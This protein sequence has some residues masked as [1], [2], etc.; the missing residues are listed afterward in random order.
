MR[1]GR[2]LAISLALNAA[3]FAAILLLLR[4]PNDLARRTVGNA[5][6][7]ESSAVPEHRTNFYW[8]SLESADYRTYIANLRAISCP[9]ET[10]QDIIIADVNKLFAARQKELAAAFSQAYWQPR[11][12]VAV[13]TRLEGEN[14]LREL[15]QEKHHLIRELLG[16]ELSNTSRSPDIVSFDFIAPE[17]RNRAKMLH[18]KFNALEQAVFAEA[19]DEAMPIDAEKLRALRRERHAELATALSGRELEQYELRYHPAADALRR[20]LVGFSVSESEFHALFHL[21]KEHEDQF[22]FLDRADAAVQQAERV[23]LDAIEQQAKAVL[24]EQ[25]Y[26]EYQRCRNPQFQ[27]LYRLAKVHALPETTA[28]TIYDFNRSIQDHWRNI[29]SDAALSPEQRAAA[30]RYFQEQLQNKVRAELGERAYKHY[31]RWGEEH[32]LQN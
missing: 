21:L 6:P 4:A 32:W 2:W 11:D 22:A 27:N 28:A 31:R 19:D 20:N 15:E 13:R 29:Q 3:L 25:R 7:A 16:V 8:R 12:T 18:E 30:L 26:A 9:E 14:Q 1:P 10:I 5:P 24:G 17:R 23:H